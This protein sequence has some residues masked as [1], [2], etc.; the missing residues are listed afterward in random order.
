MELLNSEV[1][2]RISSGIGIDSMT[3]SKLSLLTTMETC[4]VNKSI[5][6]SKISMSLGK[7]EAMLDTLPCNNFARDSGVSLTIL[8]FMFAAQVVLR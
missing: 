1:F 3:S 5:F 4:L 6:I 2:D 8:I 7:L